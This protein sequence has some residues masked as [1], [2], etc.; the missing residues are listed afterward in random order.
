LSWVLDSSLTVQ[1]FDRQE[2]EKEK[3]RNA[4]AIKLPDKSKS[5]YA[6][7]RRGRKSTSV[8]SSRLFEGVL[9]IE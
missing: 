6:V 2:R 5:Q 9:I 1:V 4:D 7:D 3:K 8:A